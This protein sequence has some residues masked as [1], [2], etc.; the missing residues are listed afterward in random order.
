M[1]GLLLQKCSL[2]PRILN[3]ARYFASQSNP[4]WIK[5]DLPSKCTWQPNS[6]K[7]SPHKHERKTKPKILPDILSH[8]GDT[9]IVQLNR[10]P[11]ERGI[12]SQ[13]LAKCEYF[14]PAGSV[15]DRIIL[16][17]IEDA[18]K[19]GKIKPGDTLIEPTSGNTG[20]GLS[21]ACA[22]RG[23]KCIIVMP[24]KI[25]Q[26]K[27]DIIRALG[28]QVVRTP[29]EAAFDSPDSH[30]AVAQSLQKKTLNSFVL[31]QF[32]N[33]SNPLAH[34]DTTAEEI[35]EQCEG[36]VDAVVGGAGTGGT[37]TG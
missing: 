34:Y 25:S 13:V 23:Y 33:A 11:Q 31:D 18:E 26:E 1:N 36:H 29:T 2:T 6:T 32:R 17:M 37:I 28:A 20:I 8:V 19:T 27:E 16:R 24:N 3:T 10:I 7:T 4:D 30:F 9:P 15:K 21:L 22:V 14:N 12:K 35:I 5:P